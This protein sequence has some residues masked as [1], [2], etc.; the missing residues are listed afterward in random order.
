MPQHVAGQMQ[1]AAVHRRHAGPDMDAGVEHVGP[2]DEIAGMPVGER[3]LTPGGSD[4]EDTNAAALDEV[5]AVLLAALRKHLRPA[6]KY[7]AFGGAD[8]FLDFSF[9]QALK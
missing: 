7:L 3:D 2:A 5:D 9:R 6:I 1:H 4:V 8:D